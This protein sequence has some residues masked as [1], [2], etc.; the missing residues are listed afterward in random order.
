MTIA[1][2]HWIVPKEHLKIAS[3]LI[4]PKEQLRIARHFNAGL[5]PQAIQVPEGR[6]TFS[7]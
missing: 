7:K 2:R 4:V 3:H 5:N 1:R 6:P